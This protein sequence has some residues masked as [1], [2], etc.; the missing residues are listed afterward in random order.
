[1]NLR[2]LNLSKRIKKI[3]AEWKARK[4]IRDYCMG[5]SGKKPGPKYLNYLLAF[6]VFGVF[7]FWMA[8]GYGE[9]FRNLLLVTAALFVTA[10]IFNKKEYTRVVEECRN[11]LAER[12]FNKRLDKTTGE[13]VLRILRDKITDA[14]PA[15]RDLELK[16][17]MLTGLYENEALAVIYRY[18]DDEETVGTRDVLYLLHECRRQGIKEVRIFTNGEFGKKAGLLGERYNIN[19]RL[20]NGFTLKRFIK[21]SDIYPSNSEIETLL[22]RES[23][24]RE[25]KIALIKKEILQR[26]KFKNYLIYSIVLFMLARFGIGNFYW[27]VS[28]GLL[29]LIMGVSS[30][31]LYREKKE[32]EIVF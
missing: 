6:L 19:L 18:V 16:E 28:F 26:N 7:A 15:V 21:G 11:K 22:K 5:E 29:L 17:D 24:K 27:N 31:L 13:D 30:L 12:E 10:Y 8:S 9:M 3:V 1:M 4:L 2:W 14:Y 20:Y 32:E 23:E 25:R